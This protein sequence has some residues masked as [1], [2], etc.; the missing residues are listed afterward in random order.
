MLQNPKPS[1]IKKYIYEYAL[2]ALTVAVITLFKMYI[3]MNNFIQTEL[4]ELVIKTTIAVEQNTNIL[5]QTR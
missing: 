2:I 5:K 1:A 3:S 4:R